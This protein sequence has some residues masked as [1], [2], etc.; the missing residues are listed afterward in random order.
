MADHM[1]S[2]ISLKHLAR[3]ADMSK[4]SLCRNF[5][6]ETEMTPMQ[7]LANMRVERAKKLLQESALSISM[8]SLEVGFNDLS[9]FIKN[10]KSIVGI[11]P[12]EYK[13]SQKK[14]A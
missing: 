13:K 2:H 3:E 6:K 1:S 12:S 5:K 11:T 7:F 14:P 8:V 4:Y 9:N 10:F